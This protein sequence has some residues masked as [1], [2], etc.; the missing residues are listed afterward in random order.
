MLVGPGERATASIRALQDGRNGAV[1]TGDGGMAAATCSERRGEDTCP[2]W[3]RRAVS[4]PLLCSMGDMREDGD[5]P[6]A[7]TGHRKE[8]P[9]SPASPLERDGHEG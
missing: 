8:A 9:G 5:T 2:A 4:A 1:G 7:H 3:G 6:G